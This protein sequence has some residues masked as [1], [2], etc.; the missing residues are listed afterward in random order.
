MG[1]T[2]NNDVYISL[3]NKK[4]EEIAATLL[5]DYTLEDFKNN[6]PFNKYYGNISS[7]AMLVM[8]AFALDFNA[9][10]VTEDDIDDILLSF[11]MNNEK[12]TNIYYE[13]QL[14]YAQEHLKDLRLEMN[15]ITGE[16]TECK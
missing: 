8:R 14:P 6:Q 7:H 11:H 10:F 2:E 1:V 12:V 16:I 5:M 13:D 9:L 15:E 3:Y 4:G